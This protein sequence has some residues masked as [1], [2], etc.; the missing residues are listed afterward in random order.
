MGRNSVFYPKAEVTI[1]TEYGQLIL[2]SALGPNSNEYPET[3]NI[4]TSSDL[5]NNE[6]SNTNQGTL[7]TADALRDVDKDILSIVTKRDIG[8]DSPTFSINL[9]YRVE[10]FA[11]I[12]SND[13]VIIKLCRPPE[14]L[15]TVMVGL[16]DDCRRNIDYSAKT[17]QR[18][19]SISGRGLCKAFLNFELGLVNEVEVSENYLGYLGREVTIE[20]CAAN[21]AIDKI[22]GVYAGNYINYVF[23]DGTKLLDRIHLSL[24]ARPD[25]TILDVSGLLN[26]Q[27]SLWQLLKEIQ[28]S[29][30][31]ELFWEM[32]DSGYPTLYLRPTPFNKDKW[33]KLPYTE[34]IDEEYVGDSIG[35]SDLETYTLYS[36]NCM[37]MLSSENQT[38]SFGYVPLWYPAYFPKYGIR[39]L[40]AVSLYTMYASAED[41][42]T[43][44]A[45]CLEG[46]KDLFNWNIKN[47]SMFNG[48]ITVRGSNRYKV[49]TRT[50]LLCDG[51]EFYI[52]GVSHMFN[53][54]DS[55]K[56]NL[57]VTRGLVPSDRFTFPW[58]CQETFDPAVYQIGVKGGNK[59]SR[60]NTET[61]INGQVATGDAKV[62]L[63][64][65]AKYVGYPYVYSKESPEEGFDC[66]GLVCYCYKQIGID[67]AAQG[68]RRTFEMVSVGEEV[69]ASDMSKWKPGDLCFCNYKSDGPHHVVLYAG[70]GKI[71]EAAS[72]QGKVI[73]RDV[74][75]DIKVVKRILKD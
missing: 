3:E 29:P 4:D 46:T 47:N 41:A 36:V 35:R 5:E 18:V 70:N 27:G 21:E 42:E 71:Y 45:K 55:Y 73:Y 66:S 15:K 74:R 40:D 34:I 38:N 49:G 9:V 48:N 59:K 51:L 68:Y 32:D 62:L 54:Y 26:Y 10:W 61:T 8:N 24:S 23:A 64:T 6:D 28:N 25:Y 1:Y 63:D 43:T 57:A 52:E 56:T 14:E 16:V 58:G 60:T 30:F 7:S 2:K 33:T 20:G 53:I 11:S 72:G 37:T 22:L 75:D 44:E 12:A 67:L 19:I 39:R 13:L 31:N 17:P 65:A 50:K 69:D